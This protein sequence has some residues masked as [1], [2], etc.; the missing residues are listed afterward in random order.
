MFLGKHLCPLD[1]QHHLVIPQKL[2]G[3]LP[4]SLYISQ[5]FDRNLWI[6]S[7]VTF[8]TIYRKVIA[9]NLADPLARLLQRLI[10]GSAQETVMND[11][12]QLLIPAELREFAG[13]Q[14]KAYLIGVGDYVEIWSTEL[15][16]KQEA[17][18]KDAQKN[19]SRFSGLIVSVH[20]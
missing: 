9:L 14:E 5:G 19:S 20:S 10:L 13:L 11:L 17:E 2:Q 6:L 3:K 15:W 4:G 18:L 16:N 8:E 12:G 7:A 1:S